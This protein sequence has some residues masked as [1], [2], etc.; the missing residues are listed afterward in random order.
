MCKLL[1]RLF[2]ALAGAGAALAAGTLIYH[3]LARF[4]G[5]IFAATEIPEDLAVRPTAP[6]AWS[7]HRAQAPG[8]LPFSNPAAASFLDAEIRYDAA[9]LPFSLVLTGVRVL[10]E[11]AARDV[12]EVEDQERVQTH[13]AV[14]NAVMG[15]TS[16]RVA[17]LRPWSGLLRTPQGRPM[18]AVA[19][20][21]AETDT[22]TLAL[23]DAGQWLHVPP[24]LRVH[25]HW[26]GSEGEARAQLPPQLPAEGARWG[27]AEG[28]RMHW[29]QGLTP[30]SGL[31]LEDG[32]EFTLLHVEPGGG[33]AGE[34]GD[35]PAPEAAH[36]A[37]D[38]VPAILVEV[39]QQDSATRHWL[40][41][42][43][44][45]APHGLRFEYP[46]A[47]PHVLLL[48]AWR[49]AG[50][51]AG[52][53]QGGSLLGIAMLDEGDV[54]TPDADFPHTLRVRQVMAGALPVADTGADVRELI[55][56][57]PEERLELR[58]GVLVR[59]ADL[60]LRYRRL[61]EPPVV[62]YQVQVAPK[63]PANGGQPYLDTMRGRW[64][65]AP[66][67]HHRSGDP[68]GAFV[69]APGETVR[70]GQWRLRQATA[71]GA[72]AGVAVLHA[73]Y[74]PGRG[75]FLLGLVLILAGLSGWWRARERARHHA[76]TRRAEA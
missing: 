12:L 6:R 49:E 20:T 34:R 72:P 74:E 31:F 9:E 45:D 61:P 28:R 8:E 44:T 51:L 25:F 64:E 3:P 75:G 4:E 59:H 36:D 41:P 32:T 21:R 76:A 48:R 52:A 22:E 33:N 27:V 68:P 29:I 16:L 11:G 13:P 10:E 67:E 73:A 69:I 63:P 38:A 17:E 70:V 66:A 58:E 2:L 39:R 40:R 26:A 18:S 46:G 24:D 19:L 50:L 62:A 57:S 30:G 7:T 56:E 35:A 71:A 47:S 15:D 14:E 53:Y 37:G 23:L 43:A 65:R 42:D 54:W 1:P 60:R 55:L 5:E